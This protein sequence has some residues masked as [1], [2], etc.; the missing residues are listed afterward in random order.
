MP[1]DPRLT[2]VCSR[3]ECPVE[4]TLRVMAE[5]RGRSDSGAWGV[6]ECVHTCA[7]CGARKSWTFT[8]RSE[9]VTGP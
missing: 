9:A 5:I 3:P 6:S 4:R 2:R 8:D 7:L 1:D